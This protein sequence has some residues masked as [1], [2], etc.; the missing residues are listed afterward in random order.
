MT[1]TQ[2]IID[3]IFQLSRILLIL[4]IVL[5]GISLV[6]IGIDYLASLDIDEDFDKLKFNIHKL[7]C[8]LRVKDQIIILVILILLN[9]FIPNYSVIK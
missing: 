6:C 4:N 9:I 5:I 2:Y 7:I 1:Y 3:N 8:T